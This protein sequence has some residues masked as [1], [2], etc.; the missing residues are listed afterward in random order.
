M[1]KK[2]RFFV[3]NLRYRG[4]GQSVIMNYYEIGV[5]YIVLFWSK[6]YNKDHKLDNINL[7]TNYEFVGGL[8][9]NKMLV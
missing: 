1:R 9:M 4:A 8:I 3:I 5:K 6:T 7:N 2:A